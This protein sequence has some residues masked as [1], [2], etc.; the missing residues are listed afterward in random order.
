MIQ[1]I[2]SLYLLIVSVLTGTSFGFFNDEWLNEKYFTSFGLV[3]WYSIVNL[4]VIFLFKNRKIQIK[5]KLL[6]VFINLSIIGL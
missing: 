1:R 6:N 4:M 2:Q 3:I 5:L